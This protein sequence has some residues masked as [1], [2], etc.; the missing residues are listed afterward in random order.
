MFVSKCSHFQCF[1]NFRLCFWLVEC[2][3]QNH[4]FPNRGWNLWS[5]DLNQ[6]RCLPFIT[7]EK[8]LLLADQYGYL[9]AFFRRYKYIP[10]HVTI[11]LSLSLVTT[12]MWLDN[13]LFFAAELPKFNAAIS[14]SQW[15]FWDLRNLNRDSYVLFDLLSLSKAYNTGFTFVKGFSIRA[16]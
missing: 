6:R 13:S 14:K 9:I 11:A 7:I 15:Y 8:V 2:V 5:H 10:S 12:K 16:G 3:L 4:K 1:S